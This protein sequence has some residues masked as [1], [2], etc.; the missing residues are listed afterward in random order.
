VLY[1]VCAPTTR[2]PPAVDSVAVSLHDGR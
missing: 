2:V 1:Q